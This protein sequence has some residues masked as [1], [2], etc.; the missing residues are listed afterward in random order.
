MPKQDK[1]D[2]GGVLGANIYT[3]AKALPPTPLPDNANRHGQ[4]RLLKTV[5]VLF[6]EDDRALLDSLNRLIYL[7]KAPGNTG[8]S[9]ATGILK[10]ALRSQIKKLLSK[11]G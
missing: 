1:P 8:D 10:D 3:E 6:Y 5:N 7:R 11:E 9:T 4:R 2:F